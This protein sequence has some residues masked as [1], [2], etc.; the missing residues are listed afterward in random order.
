MCVSLWSAFQVLCI[1]CMC[2]IINFSKIWK[3][4]NPETHLAPRFWIRDCR[5]V[6]L[7]H[8]FQVK[9]FPPFRIC[10]LPIPHAMLISSA[11]LL[12]ISLHNRGCSSP[13]FPIALISVPN[14][15]WL[16]SLFANPEDPFGFNLTCSLS[17]T[18]NCS[19]LSLWCHLFLYF[20]WHHSSL[21]LLSLSDRVTC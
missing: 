17:V 15:P 1:D 12:D 20:L 3:I 6:F 4:L 11:F 8:C 13:S 16:H 14:P 10:F 9:S 2:S 19:P 21:V 18:R 7:K 5:P